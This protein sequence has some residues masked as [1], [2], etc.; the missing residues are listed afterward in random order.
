MEFNRKCRPYS[1]AYRDMFGTIPSPSDYAC[2]NEEFLA[3]ITRAIDE[4][5]EIDQYLPKRAMHQNGI[6][7]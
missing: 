1:I 7:D 5:K 3:A 2:T 4:K 6:F